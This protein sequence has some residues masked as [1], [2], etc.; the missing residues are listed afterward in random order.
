M[1][2]PDDPSRH[3]KEFPSDGAWRPCP[4]GGRKKIPPEADERVIGQNANPEED[5]VGVKIPG[6]QIPYSHVV[7]LRPDGGNGPGP[8]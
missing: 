4:A 3:D 2:M 6:G 7:S 8:S 5:R 1:E